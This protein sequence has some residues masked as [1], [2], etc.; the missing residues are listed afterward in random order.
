MAALCGD[1]SPAWEACALEG[2]KDPY[3][4]SLRPVGQRE[5]NFSPT[6]A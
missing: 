4:A 6:V 5:E 1:A 2:V 3:A